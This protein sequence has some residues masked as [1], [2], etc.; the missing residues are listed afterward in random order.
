MATLQ[1]GST[2]RNCTSWMLFFFGLSYPMATNAGDLTSLFNENW[3]RAVV[4]IEVMT[5]PTN[6]QSIGTGFIVMTPSNHCALVTAKHVVVERGSDTNIVSGLAYRLNK[7][8]QPTYLIPEV[9]IMPILGGWIL[10]T[11]ADL[12]AR[13]ISWADQS[14][15]SPITVQ[16]LLPQSN[17]QATASIDILG[18]PMGLRSEEHQVPIVRRGTVARSD[19][20]NL[21]LDCFVFPGNSGGP[22][23]YVPVLKFGGGLISSPLVNS[24]KLV[25]I[26]ISEITYNE[27]A[28]SLQT[29]H[30]RVSFEENSGLCN[31]VPVD[32]L[33]ELMDCE[34]FKRID[35]AAETR[36]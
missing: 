7:T 30:R 4:S 1:N 33:L 23:V 9:A 28:Y 29:M 3:F 6:S 21:V 19:P 18:F 14:E 36:P 20:G 26:V 2:R 35:G 5:S 31:A 27:D 12:A 16:D 32:R 11:N 17:V 8:G 25:G 34:E 24:E 22:V 15:F 13:F 10:S